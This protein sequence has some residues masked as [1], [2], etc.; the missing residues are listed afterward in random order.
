MQSIEH[1][2]MFHKRS[3]W[4]LGV[5]GGKTWVCDGSVAMSTQHFDC[6]DAP[7]TTPAPPTTLLLRLVA[8]ETAQT[9]LDRL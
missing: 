6:L 3:C 1:Q 9:V 4:L 8:A 7:V 5:I 2:T